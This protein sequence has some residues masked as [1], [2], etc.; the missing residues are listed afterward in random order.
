M[1]MPYGTT[2]RMGVWVI[3][4]TRRPRWR[5]A[6]TT[7]KVTPLPLRALARPY[8]AYEA[9]GIRNLGGEYSQLATTLLVENEFYGTI[10]PK[11]VIRP[12]ER[13]FARPARARR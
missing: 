2:L 7:W 13:P 10:R 5:S 9:I 1:Y 8:P 6:T 3:R 11:R 4:A 12:G